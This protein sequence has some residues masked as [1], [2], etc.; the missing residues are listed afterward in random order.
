VLV[1]LMAIV[2]SPG[3]ALAAPEVSV[4]LSPDGTFTVVGNGW[5]PGQRLVVS[6]G[7]TSFA[8]W[9]DST[10]SFEVPTGLVSYQGP[11]EVHRPDQTALTMGRFGPAERPGL[12]NPLAVL[13]AQGLVSGVELAA[14][15]G[16]LVGLGI[17]VARSIRT[18]GQA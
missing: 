14:L 7:R 10:G 16:G 17:A 5:R 8:A 13:F 4:D 2:L 1:M 18:R 6:L 15:L 3:L 11:L 12:P 9:A